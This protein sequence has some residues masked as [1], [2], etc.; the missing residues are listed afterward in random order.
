VEVDDPGAVDKT[1]PD[2]VE[3]WSAFVTGAES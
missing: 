2:F 3:R 1:F